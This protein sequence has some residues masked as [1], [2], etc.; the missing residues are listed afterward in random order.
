MYAKL[1]S[2]PDEWFKSGSE[3]FLSDL[4]NFERM[5]VEEYLELKNS[6]YP[7]ECF[8]GIRVCED[9]PNE[10]AFS[11]PGEER[12]DGEWCSLDEFDMEEVNEQFGTGY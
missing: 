10:R 6:G 1:T 7:A 4:K 5:T 3:V 8:V 2:K 11:V 12:I 9:N